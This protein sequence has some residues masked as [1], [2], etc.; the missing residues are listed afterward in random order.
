VAVRVV[1]ARRPGEADGGPRDAR[2]PRRAV[3]EMDRELGV[4]E[5]LPDRGRA[6]ARGE[7]RLADPLVLL[8]ELVER[9]GRRLL[10]GRA[11]GESDQGKREAGQ[12]DGS[13]HGQNPK[14]SHTDTPVMRAMSFT[15]YFWSRSSCT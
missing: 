8:A 14:G 7:Q 5:R 13:L 11:L 2:P 3:L 1:A 6:R 9:R 4:V 10:I 12:E 15:R